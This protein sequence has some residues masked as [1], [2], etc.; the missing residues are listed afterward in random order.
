MKLLTNISAKNVEV[1]ETA[2]EKNGLEN[3]NYIQLL[4]MFI[5][6]PDLLKDIAF[7]SKYITSETLKLLEEKNLPKAFFQQTQN[8]KS[9]LV[10]DLI[11]EGFDD[12]DIKKIVSNVMEIFIEEYEATG[13]TTNWKNLSK[14]FLNEDESERDGKKISRVKDKIFKYRSVPLFNLTPENPDFQELEKEM[15][16]A[17]NNLVYILDKKNFGSK[18]MVKEIDGIINC[19]SKN[20]YHLKLKL[21][22]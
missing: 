20:N 13:K 22:E 15:N 17:K 8:P 4:R 3:K 11:A 14:L 9:R 6:D 12:S 16:K 10:R 18:P 2:S 19:L 21:E 7:H 5:E 1:C